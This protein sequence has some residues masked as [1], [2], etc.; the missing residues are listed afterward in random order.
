[1]NSIRVV[2]RLVVETVTPLHIGGPTDDQLDAPVV[3]NAFGQWFVPGSSL[4][5]VLRAATRGLHGI[6]RAN[7]VFGTI[8]GEAA[9][10]SEVCISDGELLDFDGK[11]ALQ[12]VMA[13]VPVDLPT[14]MRVVEDHVRLQTDLD[15]SP[16]TA[17]DG[18]KF[19]LEVVPVG[20]R[21]A[22]EVECEDRT[23]DG[24]APTTLEHA[25]RALMDGDIHLGGDN[26]AGLGRVVARHHQ[27]RRFDLSSA[28]DVLAYASLGSDPSEPLPGGTSLDARPPV[29][30]RR[31][32]DLHGR[33]QIEFESSGPLLVGGAQSPLGDD[34][35]AA[36]LVFN[37]QPVIDMDGRTIRMLPLI[38][39][40]SLRGLMR[41]RV[42]RALVASGLER[43]TIERE[44]AT[45]FGSAS[46]SSGERGRLRVEGCVL[47]D[48]PGTLIQ[49]VAI[50]RLTGG[51]L[52]AAL[53][54]EAPIWVDGLTVRAAIS[55]D[56]VT[57]RQLA[58]LAHAIWDVHD[59][60]APL[61]GGTRRGNG[62]LR[63][64]RDPDGWKGLAITPTLR[65]DG[66]IL[67]ASDL[68]SLERM[69]AETCL[70][71]MEAA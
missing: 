65:R 27:T 20:A 3:R 34:R 67:D 28:D 7:V 2:H 55:L 61:G 69:V 29:E 9:A 8:V 26:A 37:R 23:G 71:E 64:R 15:E 18:G 31:E 59:G 12:K 32:A 33:I 47:E 4:A 16:G 45:L 21:F 50:D 17:A 14:D 49:H 57:P 66:R 53:Y 24:L 42:I 35:S 62:R 38:P 46:G 19:D 60:T 63:I 22:F 68:E 6:D 56:G 11:S 39:G 25:I 48:H 52:K 70:N 36:D 13:G 30:T 10:S 41:S 40:S 44:I 1:M 43:A 58:L 5:G 54:S 51:S